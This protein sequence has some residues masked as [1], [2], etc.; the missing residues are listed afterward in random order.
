MAPAPTGAPNLEAARRLSG[1]GPVTEGP[2][3]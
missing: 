1:G 3:G 2:A